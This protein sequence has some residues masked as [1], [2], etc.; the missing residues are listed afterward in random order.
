M[1]IHFLYGRRESLTAKSETYKKAVRKYLE[2]LGFSQ[3][4]ESGVE[5]TF[6]DMTFYNPTIE[7]GKRFLIEAKAEEL[8][9][10]DFKL[11]TELIKYFRLWLKAS[12]GGFKF[13]L[14]AQAVKKPEQW[15]AIFSENNDVAAVNKWCE[16]YN[17]SAVKK[18]KQVLSNQ[19]MERITRFFSECNLTVANSQRLEMAICE[20]EDKATQSMSRLAKELLAI[21]SKNTMPVMK[22]STVVL[23][24]CPIELPLNYY[25]CQATTGNKNEIFEA[26][27]DKEIPPFILKSKSR[28]MYSFIQFDG[29]NPLSQ[30]AIGQ[31]KV[32]ITNRLREENPGLCSEI[33]NVFLGRMIWNRGML[34][35]KSRDIWYFPM[36]EKNRKVR[37]V[38]GPNGKK[39]WVVKRYVHLKDTKY[40]QKGETSFFFHK[41]LKLRTQIY[42]GKS[43][44]E[45]LPK[46]YYTRDGSTPISGEERKRLDLHFRK[47]QFNRA[48]TQISL[49]RFWRFLLFEPEKNNIKPES[50]LP[51]FKFGDF[52]TV[53][54]NWSPSAIER[55]QTRLWDFGGA[56]PECK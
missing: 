17:A 27:R 24:V 43:Y 5:G 10:T 28:L 6:E 29:T 48:K 38:K 2:S 14:F 34:R 42:F 39:Q 22:K 11:A 23:N 55:T 53:K 50:W 9:L 18:N 13:W 32:E 44:I 25:I 20:K 36:L 30:F 15:E 37:Q 40:G 26:L 7:P 3:T 1:T 8:S 49:M 19:E 16:W 52:V 4:T 35:D 21:V 31:Q 51:L 47:P 45:I 46:K 12:D 41:G 33:V 56:K 54:A